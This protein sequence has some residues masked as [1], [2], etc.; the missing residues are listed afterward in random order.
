[1]KQLGKKNFGLLVYQIYS[2]AIILV[3]CK[4]H[5]Q[6]VCRVYVGDHARNLND[7]H[8]VVQNPTQILQLVTH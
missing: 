8:S 3:N 2:L 4:L 7:P 5:R 1:M 6:I